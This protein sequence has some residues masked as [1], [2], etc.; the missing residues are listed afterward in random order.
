M[1]LGCHLLWP[2]SDTLFGPDGPEAYLRMPGTLFVVDGLPGKGLT[3]FFTEQ[4]RLTVV[5]PDASFNVFTTGR[6]PRRA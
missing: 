2:S 5:I 1:Q 6:H 4:F 3:L